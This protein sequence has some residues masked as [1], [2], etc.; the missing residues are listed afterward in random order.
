[1]LTE[2]Y[3]YQ[4]RNLLTM[5]LALNAKHIIF[6]GTNGSGKSNILEAIYYLCIGSSFRERKDEHLIA[7][8]KKKF[9]LKGTHSIEQYFDKIIIH[10]EYSKKEI[11]LN[12][13]K[14]NDRKELLSRYP[15]VIFSYTDI[16]LITGE[17]N[18]RRQFFDQVSSLVYGESYIIL[19]RRYQQ[20]FKQRNTAFKKDHYDFITSSDK[21]FIKVN[22]EIQKM[23]IEVI[24]RFNKLFILKSKHLFNKELF[25]NY[26]KSIKGF[27]QEDMTEFLNSKRNYEWLKKSVLFGVHRDRYELIEKDNLIIHYLSVGQKR[28]ISLLMKQ[29]LCQLILDYTNCKPIILLDDVFVELDDNYRKKFWNMLPDYEQ[30]FMSEID[31][32]DRKF[33]LNSYKVYEV[34]DGEVVL[35]QES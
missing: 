4:F 27:N 15:C 34:R 17:L 26:K 12:N 33:Y 20:I 6:K 29:V 28:M 22:D 8:D 1:M 13:V 19:L 24:N 30:L 3:L 11:Y 21:I 31:K 14:L 5:C 32:H 10:Y 23:R 9:A 16:S 25:F 35:E 18:L 7:F 2:I